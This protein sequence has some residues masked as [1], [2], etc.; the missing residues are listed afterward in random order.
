[1]LDFARISQMLK[2]QTLGVWPIGTSEAY[3]QGPFAVFRM[4]T[5]GWEYP[6][7]LSQL[8][9]LPPGAKILDCGC[10]TSGFPLELFRRGF[11]PTGLDYFVGKDQTNPGYGITEPFIQSLRG[12]VN[13]L[14]GDLAA[15]P[16]EDNTYDAAT[17]I[18]VMEHVVII[19]K[20]DPGYHLKCLDE[21]KRILKPGGLLI[22]TYDT[23]LNAK[24]VFGE[25]SPWGKSGWH[26]LD[27]IDYLRM[28]PRDPNMKRIS[29]E[30]ILM[31][32]DAFFIPPD[33]YFDQKY[34]AGFDD[35]GPY[36]RLTSVGFALFK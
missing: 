9:G 36:H 3:A 28:K 1:M 29:R 5:R 30:D 11:L 16:A 25:R 34:G 2:F 8:E 23:I 13:F 31:D 22:C 6:W 17:C 20:E 27:D 21:M 26:Y 35:F 4:G 24:V 15:I 33:F 12:K 19:H 14:N 7:V 18:S 10:G 32:E